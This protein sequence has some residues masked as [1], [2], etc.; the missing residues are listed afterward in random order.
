MP[1]NIETQTIGRI[2]YLYQ[3]R[4]QLGDKDIAIEPY[5]IDEFTITADINRFLPALR[6]AFTDS[7]GLLTHVIPLDSATNKAVVTIGRGKDV[8]EQ[9]NEYEFDIYRRF[10]N[11]RGKYDIEG[12]LS[13]DNLFSPQYVR[14]FSGTIRS[15]LMTIAEELGVDGVELDTSLNYKKSLIQ[16]SW[17]N[18]QFLTYLPFWEVGRRMFL[19]LHKEQGRGRQIRFQDTCFFKAEQSCIRKAEIQFPGR[20]PKCY[21]RRI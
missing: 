21:I 16:P 7:Q 11:S 2:G 8:L 4:F 14:S 20:K 5:S 6:V 13:V 12:L 15:T 1:S 19:C 10:P 3:L 18:A 9:Y 17:T